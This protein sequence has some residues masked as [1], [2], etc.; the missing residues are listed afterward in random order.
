MK[1]KY[2]TVKQSPNLIVMLTHKD[3]TVENAYEIFEQCKD[4]KAQYWGWKE[5][6]ISPEDMKRLCSYIKSSGKTA[7]LEVVAYTEARNA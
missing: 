3:Q 2:G 6:G 5:K 4:S 7:V 1:T